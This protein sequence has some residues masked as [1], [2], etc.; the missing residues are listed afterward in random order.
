M[1]LLSLHQDRTQVRVDFAVYGL[2][3]LGLA[4]ATLARTPWQ[5]T[6]EA[7]GWV[8]GG[9]L[10]WTLAEYALHRFVLHGLLPFSRWHGL[11]HAQPKALIATPTAFTLVLFAVLVAL[12]VWWL[13]PSWRGLAALLGVMLGYLAYIVT[14]DSVHLAPTRR[15]W[16]PRQRRWHAMHHRPGARA[17]YGVSMR[18]WDHVFGS[19]PPAR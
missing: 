8:L 12:P 4:V 16:L 1:G 9:M 10:A 11:H 7:A 14:H 3:V 15:A 6:L 17:C 5:A 18:L 2:L 13:A 19:T